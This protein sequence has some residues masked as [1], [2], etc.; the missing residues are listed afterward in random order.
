M[1]EVRRDPQSAWC[2]RCQSWPGCSP[3]QICAWTDLALPAAWSDQRETLKAE[4][5]MTTFSSQFSP[6]CSWNTIYYGIL[7]ILF[8]TQYFSS[9][10]N[11]SD[12][13]FIHIIETRYLLC[14]EEMCIGA[15]CFILS[16]F[17][18]FLLESFPLLDIFWDLLDER[19]DV[20]VFNSSCIARSNWM[21][22]PRNISQWQGQTNNGKIIKATFCKNL[23]IFLVLVN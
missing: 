6:C 7:L 9:S 8:R 18:E 15:V 21:Q 16:Q 4:N 20:R 23:W 22:S 3:S 10:S 14:L 19:H 1:R 17:C 13:F 2:C 12:K 5:R 11:V